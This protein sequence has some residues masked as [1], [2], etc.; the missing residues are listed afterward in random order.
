MMVQERIREASYLYIELAVACS[1]EERHGLSVFKWCVC[2]C[3]GRMRPGMGAVSF[4]RTGCSAEGLSEMGFEVETLD[5][6][7]AKLLLLG[8]AVDW[9]LQR[10]PSL[11]PFF[12]L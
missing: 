7:C 11:D 12:R 4:M 6:L 5:L 2:C 10:H 8:V 9:L 3:S 1:A